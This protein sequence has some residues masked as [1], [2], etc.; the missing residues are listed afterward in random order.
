MRKSWYSVFL[1]AA[2]LATALW[3]GAIVS[4]FRGEPARNK[5]TLKWITE[6]EI[7]LKGFE[8]ERGLSK[9]D[10]QKIDFVEA[11]GSLAAAS[12]A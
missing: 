12:Q 7:N 6:A 11:K 10:L 3:A 9:T 2:G 4:E 5:V 1:L 8:I